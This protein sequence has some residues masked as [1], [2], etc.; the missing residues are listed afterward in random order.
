[1]RWQSF[2]GVWSLVEDIWFFSLF[3]FLCESGQKEQKA[4]FRSR[5]LLRS[6][7]WSFCL[8]SIS[9]SI[10]I[11]KRCEGTLILRLWDRYLLK[12]T[13][14]I[15]KVAK[16]SS[17]IS[18]KLSNSFLREWLVRREKRHFNVIW[19]S[20]LW[21]NDWKCFWEL[22]LELGHWELVWF[23]KLEESFFLFF[24]ILIIK[25]DFLLFYIII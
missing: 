13:A 22:L 16:W 3:F 24:K 17:K 11:F 10:L 21:W 8:P 15:S 25:F 6:M 1:M 4:D 5:W 2:T 14:I 12:E 9:I 20:L 19:G 18:A 7:R 23:F